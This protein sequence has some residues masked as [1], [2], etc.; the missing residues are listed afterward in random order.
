MFGG[1]QEYLNSLKKGLDVPNI[2]N[3]KTNRLLNNT[4]IKSSKSILYDYKIKTLNTKNQ[5]A[6]YLIEYFEGIMLNYISLVEEQGKRMDELKNL[7]LSHKKD[8]FKGGKN[9]YL[10][11][12]P[13]YKNYTDDATK[14]DIDI[15]KFINIYWSFITIEVHIDYQKEYYINIKHRYATEGENNNLNEY[16][17]IDLI[18]DLQHNAIIDKANRLRNDDISINT[19]NITYILETITKK[20]MEYEYNDCPV[21][22]KIIDKIQE[23][24]IKNTNDEETCIK[25]VISLLIMILTLKNNVSKDIY[26]NYNTTFLL[27]GICKNQLLKN[28]KDDDYNNSLRLFSGNNKNILTYIEKNHMMYYMGDCALNSLMSV[29]N[30]DIRELFV[31]KIS[32]GVKNKKLDYINDSKYYI[33]KI[34]NVLTQMKN[35][36]LEDFDFINS[37]LKYVNEYNDFITYLNNNYSS[38]KQGLKNNINNITLPQDCKDCFNK[39]HDYYLKFANVLRNN[40]FDYNLMTSEA[41]GICKEAI[42]NIKRVNKLIE[43]EKLYENLC[44]VRVFISIL[45]KYMKYE[46]S[47]CIFYINLLISL[48]LIKYKIDYLFD[49]DAINI[50]KHTDNKINIIQCFKNISNNRNEIGEI[51]PVY[52]PGYENDKY[53]FI[54]ANLKDEPH[55]VF[56]IVDV[57]SP[58]KKMYLYD[59]NRLYLVCSE[60]FYE[61]DYYELILSNIYVYELNNSYRWIRFEMNNYEPHYKNHIMIYFKNIEDLT[62]NCSDSLL[63]EN[64]IKNNL[65]LNNINIYNDRGNLD[66]TKLV[67]LNDDDY[68]ENNFNFISYNIK[69]QLFNELINYSNIINNIDVNVCFSNAVNFISNF[70]QNNIIDKESC[71]IGKLLFKFIECLIKAKWVFDNRAFLPI[72]LNKEYY[73]IKDYFDDT[74]HLTNTQ[75]FVNYLGFTDNFNNYHINYNKMIVEILDTLTF[76]YLSK[77]KIVRGGYSNINYNN[78]IKRVL[79]ILLI[80]VI[81]IIIVL[82]VLFIINKYNIPK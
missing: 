66:F 65:N 2:H 29:E 18:I 44:G 1:G 11:N 41:R 47:F 48:L 14:T 40:L 26:K 78:I 39:L 6:D 5:S 68:N 52:Q 50:L 61:F 55:A 53:I 60:D 77:D 12:D 22:L 30:A 4:Q 82:I 64:I 56:L 71:S 79:I 38:L 19:I 57:G 21:V 42:D 23:K 63:F 31:D 72:N 28:F 73:K 76:T 17:K 74:Y 9:S 37:I 33:D 62:D 3:I 69:R 7:I 51:L 49:D 70:V 32:Y 80:I 75:K 34:N 67:T 27:S 20:L 45:D 10:D 54:R 13:E 24:P 15:K 8:E 46:N 36:Q 16:N 43:S 35:Y 58:N 81:I 25:S 59:L